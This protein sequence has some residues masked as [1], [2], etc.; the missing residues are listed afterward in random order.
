MNP[1]PFVQL[2]ALAVL[3]VVAATVAI[4]DANAALGVAI[5]V[6]V[7]AAIWSTFALTYR[8]R[9]TRWEETRSA[10]RSGRD[11]VMTGCLLLGLVLP[12]G[13]L[14]GAAL[15]GDLNVIDPPVHGGAAVILALG[16]ATVPLS[17]LVSSSVD[18]YL[19]RAFREGVHGSPVCQRHLHSDAQRMAYARYWA[20]HRMVS[21]FFVYLGVAGAVAAGLVIAS[22]GTDS[23]SGKTLLSL[24]GGMGLA[25]WAVSEMGK[26]RQAIPFVRFPTC[27]LGDWVEGRNDECDDISGFVL[28]VALDPGVQLIEE[29]RGYPA[30]DISHPDRSIPLTR[31]RTVKRVPPPREFCPDG[32]CEF[33][34]PDCEVG[35][36]ACELQDSEATSQ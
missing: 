22:E 13:L 16:A 36:R 20:L 12:A 23:E 18:W 9:R 33:W 5:L 3:L 26:V 27:G 25:I 14:W 24:G 1:K 19:I 11:A 7:G 17:M 34:L 31:R 32:T 30:E 35:V 10:L 4:L 6:T 15:V 8:L 21:E 28:D 29:P 2:Q